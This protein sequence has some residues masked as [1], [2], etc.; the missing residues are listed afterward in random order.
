MAAG[1]GVEGEYGTARTSVWWDIENCHVPKGYDAHVIA[2]NITS[3]LAAVGYKGL[4]TIS[5]YGDTNKIPTNVQHALSGTGIAL[6]HVPSGVKDASDKKILVDMLFWAVDNPPPANYLLISGDRDFS[7]ALHQLRM[8]RYNILLA[9]APN[10]SQALVAAAK[11]VWHWTSLLAGGL[12]LLNSGSTQQGNSSNGKSSAEIY[13]F[14]VPETGQKKQ[15]LEPFSDISS[16]GNQKGCADGKADNRSKVKPVW[17]TSSQVN[18]NKPQT[19]SNDFR[20]LSLGDQE[21]CASVGFDNFDLKGKQ[22]LQQPSQVS[23]PMTL[24]SQVSMPIITTSQVSTSMIST[25]LLKPSDQPNYTPA[26]ASYSNLPSQKPA[27]TPLTPQETPH[28]FCTTNMPST[29]GPSPNVPFYPSHPL[30][31]EHHFQSGHQKQTQN[32][33]P[34]RPSGL[35]PLQSTTTSSHL[36]SS[37]SPSLRPGVPSFTP[38]LA[39]LPMINN[40]SV[41]KYPNSINPPIHEPNVVPGLKPFN[42]P[43]ITHNKMPRPQ[44]HPANNTMPN[45]TILG[46]TGIPLSSSGDQDMIGRI[47]FA[48]NSL[49]EEK[50]APTLSNITDCVQYGEMKLKN[51]DVN[52]GL[53]LAIKHQVV[54][55]HKLG[56]NLPFFIG[57]NDKLWKCVNVM[58]VTVRHPKA[59]WDIVQKFLCSNTG[60]SALMAS[61]CQYEAAI[62][63]KKSCLSNLAVGD[64]LQLLYAITNVKKW[65]TPHPSGWQPLSITIRV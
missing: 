62:I 58:D 5:V 20:Q 9:H 15:H 48:L 8:R 21:G 50:L 16:L 17:R 41:S 46:T 49:K 24:T 12:P 53:E 3:A 42:G 29:S 30:N 59:T 64:V 39:N 19:L 63:L 10:V 51:F 7:N 22:S 61:Q 27:D 55:M 13:K 14:T 37:Y 47:L 45:N 36:H 65:V 52:K 23:M 31:N 43:H 35:P 60:R 6:N 25:S 1:E 40:P 11:T 32:S 44:L 38:A 57:R 2:Q 33:Q 28:R 26:S 54:V 18:A 4:V 56:G 34:L